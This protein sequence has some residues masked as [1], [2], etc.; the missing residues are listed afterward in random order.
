MRGRYL[1]MKKV[2]L[3]EVTRNIASENISVCPEL[4]L[5]MSINKREERPGYVCFP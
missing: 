2:R 1:L 4:K 5:S 3:G